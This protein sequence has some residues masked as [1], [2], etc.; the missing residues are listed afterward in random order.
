MD[1][2]IECLDLPPDARG[3]GVSGLVSLRGQPL[4]YL[5]LRELFGLEG[6]PA[7]RENVV[8]VRNESGQAG[9]VVDALLGGHQV[10]IKPLGALFRGVAAVAGSAILGDGRAALILDV[11]KLLKQV[12][13]ERAPSPAERGQDADRMRRSA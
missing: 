10:V 3:T 4:P 12:L 1:S 7:V 9:F 11:S 13:S 8:V 2:V 5:R 6:P